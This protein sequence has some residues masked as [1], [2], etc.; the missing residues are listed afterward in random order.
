MRVCEEG[1]RGLGE[2]SWRNVLSGRALSAGARNFRVP[3]GGAAGGRGVLAFPLI[4]LEEA[5]FG[6]WR[7]S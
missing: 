2:L 1:N 5:A 4:V 3:Q 6:R 7:K